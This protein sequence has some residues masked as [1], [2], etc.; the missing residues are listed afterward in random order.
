MLRS[1]CPPFASLSPRSAVPSVGLLSFPVR[2]SDLTIRRF[3]CLASLPR[4]APP[5][6]PRPS[7]SHLPS[8]AVLSL[9]VAAALASLSRLPTLPSP[10]ASRSTASPGRRPAR[11]AL[12]SPSRSPAPP[13]R[14]L[15]PIP[16]TGNEPRPLGLPTRTKRGAVRAAAVPRLRSCSRTRSPSRSTTSPRGCRPRLPSVPP[17]R[18]PRHRRSTLYVP[19]LSCPLPPYAPPQLHRR[20]P[21]APPPAHV[22]AEMQLAEARAGGS[23][24]AQLGAEED[25]VGRIWRRRR[26]LRCGG[27]EGAARRRPGRA[28][29][30]AIS[31]CCVHRPGIS[32]FRSVSA[33]RFFSIA[34]RFNVQHQRLYQPFSFI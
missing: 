20:P 5:P 27:T 12:A 31:S 21:Y 1:S 30:P 22:G 8:R 9:A 24:K 14:P 2:S 16:L 33:P 6:L 29:A 11:A 17:L 26:E 18:R 19:P 28:R 3:L 13:P 15:R 32:V 10:S 7:A 23:S 34:T 4:P 25:G